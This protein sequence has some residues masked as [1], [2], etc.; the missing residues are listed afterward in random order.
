MNTV[1]RGD[2][3]AAQ[4]DEAVAQLPDASFLY[5]S[6]AIDYYREYSPFLTEDLSFLLLQNNRVC[7]C[8]PLFLEEDQG[9]VMFSSAG[10]YGP[11]PLVD[12]SGS[13]KATEHFMSRAMEVLMRLAADHRVREIK[14]RLD[15]LVNPE[16]AHKLLN[17]NVLMKYGFENH[18]IHSRI[19]DLRQS[20]EEL[21]SD[22]SKG[23][24]GRIRQ[25]QTLYRTEWYNGDAISKEAFLVYQDM[26]RLASG[27]VT[28]PQ[29]T[30]DLMYEWIRAGKGFLQMVKLE[31][32]YINATILYRQGKTAY[33][34]SAADHPGIDFPK[35][36]GHFAQWEMM[37]SLKREQVAFYETGWQQ[38]SDQPYDH[39]T[40]KDINISH[41]KSLFGGYDVPLFRG[42]KYLQVPTPA[43]G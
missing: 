30:F 15:P 40:P 4:W 14:M 34:A 3:S 39:P 11:A 29:K 13:Y 6:L 25:A 32:A 27:R 20:E 16:A 37:R 42:V 24:R 9:T 22:L 43:P 33:Y 36:V 26:H 23:T 18:S 21:W 19:V 31:D 10:S 41:F 1:F 38:F 35:P 5:Y 28:R 8:V 7:A 2:I 12:L 17:Y